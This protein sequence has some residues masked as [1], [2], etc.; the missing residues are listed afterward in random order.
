MNRLYNV[1]FSKYRFHIS[2]IFLF[3][4]TEDPNFC[5]DC[6]FAWS[7]SNI[8]R[9]RSAGNNFYTKFYCYN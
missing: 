4:S 7:D 8:P 1:H 6:D 5:I 3:N 2:G 9:S